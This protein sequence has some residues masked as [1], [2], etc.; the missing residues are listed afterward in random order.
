MWRVTAADQSSDVTDKGRYLVMRS[1]PLS[2]RNHSQRQLW[3]CAERVSAR[4]ATVVVEA[5]AATVDGRR[6]G[7]EHKVEVGALS[8]RHLD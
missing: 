7:L 6:R 3:S 8:T 4:A 5:P 2:P 1:G